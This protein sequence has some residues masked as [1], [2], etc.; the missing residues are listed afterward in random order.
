MGEDDT[1]LAGSL[2]QVSVGGGRRASL[3]LASSDSVA[4]SK[5]CY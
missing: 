5:A 3:A 4:L 1:S 2:V